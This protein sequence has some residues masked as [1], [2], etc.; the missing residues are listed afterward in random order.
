[1]TYTHEQIRE[2]LEEWT[3]PTG[4][5]NDWV[6]I[7]RVWSDAAPQIVKQLLEDVEKEHKDALQLQM[8]A[9]NQAEELQRLQAENEKLKRVAEAEKLEREQALK[10][11]GVEK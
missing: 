5:G 11:L 1:M 6:K 3:N 10:N 2:I 4:D 8:K 9:I 7:D